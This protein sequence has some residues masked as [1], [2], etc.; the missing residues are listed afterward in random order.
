MEDIFFSK[1]VIGVNRDQYRLH[2]FSCVIILETS[3]V[4]VASSGFVLSWAQYFMSAQAQIQLLG[5]SVKRLKQIRL[6]I[7][8]PYYM[9][10]QTQNLVGFIFCIIF[11]FLLFNMIIK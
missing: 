6:S 7:S 4:A 5:L 8:S 3:F 11:Y 9:G 1:N 10:Q 2:V